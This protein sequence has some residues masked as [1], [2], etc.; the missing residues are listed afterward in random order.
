M[1]SHNRKTVA[2]FRNPKRPRLFHSLDCNATVVLLPCAWRQAVIQHF[3]V[4]PVT[5]LLVWLHFIIIKRHRIFDSIRIKCPF[6]SHMVL[7]HHL[8]FFRY[9][10]GQRMGVLDLLQLVHDR[11]DSRYHAVFK[12]NVRVHCRNAFRRLVKYPQ[13][14]LALFTLIA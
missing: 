8:K 3:T 2:K 11:L 1:V 10:V 9:R 14:R 5:S 6:G 7:F 4:N 13:S 12:K